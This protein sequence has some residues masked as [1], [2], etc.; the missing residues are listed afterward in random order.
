MSVKIA[1]YL[2][3]TLAASIGPTDTSIEVSSDPGFPDI[4]QPG[5]YFRL[6][7]VNQTTGEWEIVKVT[8]KSGLILTV[9][10]GDEN[11]VAK[12]FDSGAYVEMWL[13]A[14]TIYDIAGEYTVDIDAPSGSA[15]EK[16][17]HVAVAATGRFL[18]RCWLEDEAT[19]TGNPTLDPPTGRPTPIWYEV[20]DANGEK[21]IVIKHEGA[22]K[23]W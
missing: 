11:T 7:L 15:T 4:S 9:E 3:T 6:T 23:T 13:T 22:A 21:D 8:A 18:L 10:R 5:D 16:T 2:K 19:P 17:V 20:T 1:N 14:Q 12:S